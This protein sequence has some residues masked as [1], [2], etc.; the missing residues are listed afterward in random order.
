MFF[1]WPLGLPV[2]QTEEHSTSNFLGT[3]PGNLSN[4]LKKAQFLQCKVSY[5]RYVLKIKILDNTDNQS[6]KLHQKDPFK[7][8]ILFYLNNIK[9]QSL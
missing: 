4:Q 3:I 5:K 8:S 9:N 6:K 2:A 7:K 1:F